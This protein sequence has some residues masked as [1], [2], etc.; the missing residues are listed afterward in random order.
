[1]FL[2]VCT[3]CHNFDTRGATRRYDMMLG[4]TSAEAYLLLNQEEM[5][6]GLE[7]EGR[8]RQCSNKS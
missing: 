4:V 6:L 1:M 8:N 5:E 2:K 3:Y 7:V